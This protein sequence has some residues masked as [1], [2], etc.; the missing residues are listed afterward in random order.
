MRGMDAWHKRTDGVVSLRGLRARS[1]LV[2]FLLILFLATMVAG[3]TPAAAPS[4]AHPPTQDA[5]ASAAAPSADARG[6]TQGAIPLRRSNPATGPAP[7]PASAGV[8]TWRL[9]LAL[10]VVLG[11][12]FL[13]R[14]L[15][16][17]V[18]GHAPGR[19]SRAIQVVSRST[20]AP[21][22]Q[23]MLV[24]VGRRLVLVG[25][26]GTSMSPL[27]EIDDADEVAQVLGQVQQ[28]K[29][30]SI[31]RAFSGLFRREEEKFAAGEIEDTSAPEPFPSE[32]DRDIDPDGPLGT[33]KQELHELLD[34]VRGMTST[35]RK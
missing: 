9:V 8:Q 19:N 25:N 15:G 32:Q 5:G 33:T 22:Q 28:E 23:L 20:I 31:S 6:E 12:I 11:L 30:E 35:F 29:S 3:Q 27:C 26:C 10:G 2:S 7:A 13:L 1:P 34:K 18:T 17:R 21:R 16:R 14:W 4:A 24:Q